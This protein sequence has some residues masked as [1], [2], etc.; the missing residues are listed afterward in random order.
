[1]AEPI[2]ACE[3]CGHEL[4]EY[5]VRLPMLGVFGKPAETT[6]E[7]IYPAKVKCCRCGKSYSR[8]K[9]GADAF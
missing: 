9:V 6:G 7:T 4:Y 1:M 3:V 2:E 5:V 8:K